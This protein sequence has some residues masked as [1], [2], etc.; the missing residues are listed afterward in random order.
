MTHWER[1]DRKL[2]RRREGMRVSGLALKKV[3]LP[4]L[5]K[6]AREAER[7]IE[8][9]GPAAGAPGARGSSRRGRRARR[10]RR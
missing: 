8:S 7:A 3:L 2:Q 6:R 5:E 10:G 9:E 4:L 1:R